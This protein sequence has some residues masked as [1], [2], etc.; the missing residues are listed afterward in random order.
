MMISMKSRSSFRFL[1]WYIG[2]SGCPDLEQ[3]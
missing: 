1:G 3:V 2:A